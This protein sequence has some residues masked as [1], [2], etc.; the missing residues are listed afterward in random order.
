M[1]WFSQ[2]A[3][4]GAEP[5]RRV[6]EAVANVERRERPAPP[7]HSLGIDDE[8]AE[9]AAAT[10]VAQHAGVFAGKVSEP[11]SQL[12]PP[13]LCV[14]SETLVQEDLQGSKRLTLGVPFP[15][16]WWLVEGLVRSERS[17]CAPSIE[18]KRDTHL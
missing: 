4:G 15:S 13:R 14:L 17:S 16:E 6:L 8:G 3:C 11:S 12:L 1:R 10:H 2:E 9:E 5:I 18:R 7:I